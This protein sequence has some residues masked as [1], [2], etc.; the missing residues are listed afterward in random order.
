MDNFAA[1]KIDRAS[2]CATCDR[3][4]TAIIRISMAIA[5][6]VDKERR[7]MEDCAWLVG[8]RKADCGGSRAFGKERRGGRASR[9]AVTPT[10]HHRSRHLRQTVS[11]PLT[12]TRLAAVWPRDAKQPSCLVA[13]ARCQ[14]PHSARDHS[15]SGT[16]FRTCISA[17]DPCI[18]HEY[19]RPRVARHGPASLIAG[20][21]HI[22][23]LPARQQQRHRTTQRSGPA[24]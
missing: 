19:G 12:T 7:S 10:T 8:T 16:V 4:P 22:L 21:L 23:S 24:V 11:T 1:N 17:P 5:S 20:R 13:A 15:A 18:P 3:I 2:P 6:G 9:C 14:P